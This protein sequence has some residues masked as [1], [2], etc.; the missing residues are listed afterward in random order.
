MTTFSLLDRPL[1]VMGKQGDDE[2]HR[3]H[4]F[5]QNIRAVR[6]DP[7]AMMGEFDVVKTRL[8]FRADE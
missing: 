8:L 2:D 1:C 3:T 7:R 4:L 5:S 6:Y